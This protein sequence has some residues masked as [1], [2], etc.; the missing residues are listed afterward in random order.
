M[1]TED[2]ACEKRLVSAHPGPYNEKPYVPPDCS[3]SFAV[4]A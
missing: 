2:S 3:G 1:E 4:D